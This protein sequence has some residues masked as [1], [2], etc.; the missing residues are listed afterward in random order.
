M[1]TSAIK[2]VLCLDTTD[3]LTVDRKELETLL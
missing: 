1:D 2:A 3:N